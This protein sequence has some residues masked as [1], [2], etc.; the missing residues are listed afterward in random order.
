MG[1]Q[2]CPR[3]DEQPNPEAYSDGTPTPDKWQ[4]WSGNSTC[5]YCGSMHPDDFMIVARLGNIDLGPTDKNYKVY[6]GNTKFYFQ[7]LSE[8]QKRE[9]VGLYNMR[10]RRQYNVNDLSF[11]I[12]ADGGGKMVVG[13]PGRFYVLPFFMSAS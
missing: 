6:V 1:T 7:H 8:N 13:Y 5:S 3:R 2:R 12:V 10:P 11:K 9:F 4:N